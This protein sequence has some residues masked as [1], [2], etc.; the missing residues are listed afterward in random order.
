MDSYDALF[1]SFF[2][3]VSLFPLLLYLWRIGDAHESRHVCVWALLRSRGLTGGGGRDG[4]LWCGYK[5]ELGEDEVC[6]GGVFILLLLLLPMM[7]LLLLLLLLPLTLTLSRESSPLSV[8]V[9]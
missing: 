8:F 7:L 9:T 3:P 1:F 2:L 6:L 4:G 5:G